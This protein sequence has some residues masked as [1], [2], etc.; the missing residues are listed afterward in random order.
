MK[1]IYKYPTQ[2]AKMFSFKMPKGAE[3]LC[4]QVDQ[5]TGIPCIWALID[6]NIPE[7]YRDFELFGTGHEIYYDMG[8]E[9][10]YIGTY[11]LNNGE[12]VGHIFERIN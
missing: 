10:K 1:K 12:F 5:K 9:R 8:V 7:E 6:P 2:H 11:Q 4:V 3:I